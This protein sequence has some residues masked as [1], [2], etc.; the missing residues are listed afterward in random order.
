VIRSDVLVV[1]RREVENRTWHCLTCID[2]NSINENTVL[3]LDVVVR[4]VAFKG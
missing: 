2:S 1:T 3:V 4:D